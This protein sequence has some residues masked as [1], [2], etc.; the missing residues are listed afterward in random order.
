MLLTLVAVVAGGAGFAMGSESAPDEA[1]AA[2]ARDSSYGSAYRTSL[3]ESRRAASGRGFRSGFK[4]GIREG[5]GAGL[6]SGERSGQASAETEIA[7]I[8]EAEAAAAAADAEAAAE[9]DD[10]WCDT[11]GYCLQRSPGSGGPACPPGT[12]ENAGGVVCVPL[13]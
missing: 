13:P 2:S 1:D 10:V 5:R 7:S 11:D 6:S 8:A 4:E 3:V 12:V 9:N